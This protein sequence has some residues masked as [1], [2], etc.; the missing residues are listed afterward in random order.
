MTPWQPNTTTTSNEQDQNRDQEPRPAT[1]TDHYAE[2]T[3]RHKQQDRRT[4]GSRERSR[5][6][7][8]C[9]TILGYQPAFSRLE[10]HRPRAARLLDLQQPPERPSTRSSGC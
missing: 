2:Q 1:D 6:A 3:T 9:I 10:M 5:A 4:K 7:H 8:L